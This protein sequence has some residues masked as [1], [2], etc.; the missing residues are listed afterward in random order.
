MTNQ[1]T[2]NNN[3]VEI[4]IFVNSCGE[5]ILDIDSKKYGQITDWDVEQICAVAGDGMDIITDE[6]CDEVELEI[7]EAHLYEIIGQ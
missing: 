7:T 6:L 4:T 5:Y 3:L 1:T 2:D